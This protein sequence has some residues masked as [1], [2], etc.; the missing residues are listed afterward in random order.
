MCMKFIILYSGPAVPSDASHEGWMVW[1]KNLGSALVDKGSP[2]AQGTVLHRDGTTTDKD[3]SAT[4]NGYSII[5]AKD[6]AA[7][8]ELVKTHPYLKLSDEFTVEI[9]QRG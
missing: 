3:A 6:K 8:I 9:F 1:F 7:A 5:Q 2:L 4:F